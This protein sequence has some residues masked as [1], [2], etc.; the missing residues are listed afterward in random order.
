M[1]KCDV[2]TRTADWKD[3]GINRQRIKNAA[4]MMLK[5]MCLDKCRLSVIILQMEEM[6][7]LNRTYRKKD[8][9]TDVISFANRDE[10]I[11]T[12]PGK[13][14]DLGDVYISID[15]CRRQ[16]ADNNITFDDE[17]FRLLA[18]GILHLMGLDHERSRAEEK[19]MRDREDAL[20]M[21]CKSRAM[22]LS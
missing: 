7:D 5:E 4:S 3:L 6:R 2:F 11:P 8:K 18:H 21:I 20:L 10:P 22:R 16:A 19:R 14:E 17:F 13:I 1:V 9:S 15:D 12:P